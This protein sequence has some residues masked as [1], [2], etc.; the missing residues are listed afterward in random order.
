MAAGTSKAMARLTIEIV[1]ADQNPVE[2]VVV[3]FTPSD[4]QVSLGQSEIIEI[5]QK[6]RQF[7]P[8]VSVV[9][10]GSRISFPNFDN[11]RHH[12][13][14][15]SKAKVFELRLL[16]NE[17][18]DLVLL[19]KSGTI[20]VGCNIHDQMVGFIRVVDTP[21]HGVTGTEGLYAASLPPGKYQVEIWHPNLDIEY[22]QQV[23]DITLGAEGATYRH[24][25][26]IR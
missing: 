24:A 22:A 17:R 3:T 14:S 20:I 25:L 23:A 1:G 12:V 8:Q 13:Y 11:L 26:P 15:F 6:N 18:P 19:D 21:Y 2:N 7:M 10:T 5:G 4:T 9:T 16:G